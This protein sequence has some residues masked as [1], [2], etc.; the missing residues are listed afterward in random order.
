MPF[1]KYMHIPGIDL[2]HRFTNN[3]LPAKQVESVACQFG[4]KLILTESF[5]CCG[6]D[7]K[8][9]ELKRIVDSQFVNGVNLLCHHLIPFS[10][11]GHR[12]NDYPAHFSPL[13]P[14]V[15]EKFDEFNIY[16]ERLGKLIVQS[17]T[18][19]ETEYVYE[20]DGFQHWD[21]LITNLRWDPVDGVSNQ[22][23]TLKS[24]TFD[25]AD[26]T[27][28]EFDFTAEGAYNTYLQLRLLTFVR[29]GNPNNEADYSAYCYP[30]TS[31]PVT[32]D[33]GKQISVLAQSEAVDYEGGRYKF[34]YLPAGIFA[35]KF[36]NGT[37]Q[38]ISDY[39]A[40]PA[41]RDGVD[42][43]LDSDGIATYSSDRSQLRK[44]VITG[45]KMPKAEEMNVVLYESKYHDSGF[46]ERG[47]ELPKSGGAGTE[48]YTVGGFLMFTSAAFVLLNKQKRRRKS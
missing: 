13:N 1:Y 37:T 14:W 10:E 8:P 28:R 34:N 31:T 45:I 35:V 4:K 15:R 12:K 48:I 6:W 39:I 7:V 23:F 29:Y 21:G 3:E 40:S 9:S 22:S 25:L 42:D 43:A 24:I 36:E 5:A 30:R 16:V 19:E 32:V 27:T 20:T 18:L 17:N 26:G 33:T 47:Y 46:Y 11:R 38:K 2:L 44:T 41:N